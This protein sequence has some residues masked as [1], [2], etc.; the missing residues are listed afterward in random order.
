MTIDEA[1]AILQAPKFGDPQCIAAARV[2]REAG[3]KT[4]QEVLALIDEITG[5]DFC[6]DLDCLAAFNPER[7][8]QK[9]KGCHEK[10]SLIYKL[11]HSFNRSTICHHVHDDWRKLA[12]P[13]TSPALVEESTPSQ[14]G[15]EPKGADEQNERGAE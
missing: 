6:F 14:R 3:M 1:K 4:D 2:T 8:S 15:A 13:P 5:D 9:E 7:L 10:L 12:E 11:A